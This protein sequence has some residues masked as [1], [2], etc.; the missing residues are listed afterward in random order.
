MLPVAS[1]PPTSFAGGSGP[2]GQDKPP[3]KHRAKVKTKQECTGPHPAITSRHGLQQEEE[4]ANLVLPTRCTASEGTCCP[5]P[6]VG[7]CR[8]DE[9]ATVSSCHLGTGQ[10]CW[11]S[12]TTQLVGGRTRHPSSTFHQVRGKSCDQMTQGPSLDTNSSRFIKKI[13]QV[14][15]VL[16]TE[17]I[18][19]LLI[20]S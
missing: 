15:L 3:S 8:A 14:G 10:S 2:S 13:R 6:C 11:D 19:K 7:P 5:V 16:N 1:A 4:A 17:I 12:D 20:L 18:F 9:N